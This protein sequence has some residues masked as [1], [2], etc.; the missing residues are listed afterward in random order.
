[1]K[2]MVSIMFRLFYFLLFY[3]SIYSLSLIN[4][5]MFFSGSLNNYMLFVYAAALSSIVIIPICISYINDHVNFN[6]IKM[7]LLLSLFVMLF[8]SF[9]AYILF[10]PDTDVI[11]ETASH[12]IS[13]INTDTYNFINDYLLDKMVL[14]LVFVVSFSIS[15][16]MWII[17]MVWSVKK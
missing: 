9:S 2:K 12:V 8:S 6:A 7:T 11:K 13:F 4:S 15:L 3:S 14:Y 16:V 10:I 17:S 5:Y 1:M